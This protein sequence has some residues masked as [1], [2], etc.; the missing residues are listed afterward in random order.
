[1]FGTFLVAKVALCNALYSFD[2]E[3]SYS[4]P[5]EFR[6]NID[7]GTRVLVPFGKGNRKRIGFVTRTYEMDSHNPDLKPVLQ[8]IDKKTLCTDEM[9]RIIFWLKENT[10]CT[11]YEAFKTV[12]PTGFAYNYKQHYTLVNAELPNGLSDE[13]MSV[14]AFLKNAVSSKEIDTFLDFNAN[15]SKKEVVMG[16]IEKG[17]IEETDEFKRRV[18]DET[19][20]MVSLTDGYL[21]GRVVKKLTPKQHLVVEFL[22]EYETASVK[23]ICYM[24]NV[25][26]T[27]IKNLVKAQVLYMYEYEVLRSAV[28]AENIERN[29]VKSIALNDMQKKA[30]DG[31]KNLSDNGKPAGALLF[32]VTGSGKTSVFIKLI[33][34]VLSKGKSA[35]LLVPE[36]S[37]TPQMVEKFISCFGQTVAVIHSNLSLGQRID[38]F[39][40]I[41]S[42]D[43][44][45]IIGT[46]SAIFAPAVDLGLIVMDEEGEHTYKSESSP[47]Y[48]AR[49][50]AIQRCGFN[51]ALLVMA[52]ATPSIETYYYA[53][54]GRFSFF[55]LHERYSGA[56]LPEVV[57]VDMFED[58]MQDTDGLLSISLYEKLK[59]NLKEHHQSIL[60]LNRRGYNNYV[61]CIDCHQT[62]EC[63]NCSIPLTYHKKNGRMMCHYCGY[64]SSFPKVCPKCGSEKLKTHGTGTQKAEDII[65]KLL[66]DARIIRMDADTTNSK[67]SYEKN[68]KDFGD[69]KY[70]I[71]LGT[72]MIAKGLDFPNV[73]LVGV[74]SLDKIL[75]MGDYKSYERAFSLITQVVGR[76]GRGSLK[77]NAY[78]Q[79]FVPEHYVI[80]L[81]SAQDYKSF[82]NDEIKMRKALMY[83]P[84]CDLCVI[85]FSSVIDNEAKKGSEIFVQLM[86]EY[87]QENNV[88]FPLR[89]LGPAQCAIGKINNKYRYRLIIKCK[90][91]KPFRE[92]I[93][94]LLKSAGKRREFSNVY[95]YAD[96]NGDTSL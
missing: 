1:M 93:K 67:F 76:S 94:C 82:Y 63:P 33:D 85:G 83:P 26:A 79:T 52:S 64:T 18:G 27:I 35:L 66:P 60:L 91:S 88:T 69:G 5:N 43:A 37:L 30:F 53:M 3:Y 81:A 57:K 31:L 56:E 16:L 39:K 14:V 77:G 48:H 51:N 74:L 21:N 25:T 92:M 2:T 58:T 90:N 95:V 46:R 32:G 47:R 89:V 59:E 17:V 55:E 15:P 34:Y 49:D 78:L 45:I 23:E 65:Q 73:T 10:F 9:M 40:R 62:V 75:F 22:E 36:I 4:V 96:I 8:V 71:M 11:F 86:K 41:K 29:D 54:K 20:K 6:E 72:Q 7:S 19:A 24:T 61:S 44:K 42:G 70:D 12:V 84:F 50:V 68:F 87:I 38:E 13:E 28:D 80:E